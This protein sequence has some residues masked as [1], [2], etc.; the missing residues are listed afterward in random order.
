[1]C[2]F[3]GSH[4]PL[5]APYHGT[6][7]PGEGDGRGAGGAGE[8]ERKAGEL[9]RWDSWRRQGA[10]G[11]ELESWGRGMSWKRD[12]SVGRTREL[13]KSWELKGGTWSELGN[14]ERKSWQPGR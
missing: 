8:L 4:T 6:G 14:S 12:G 7:K 5:L 1:M 2:Q 9:V 11:G 3:S 13:W 10:N